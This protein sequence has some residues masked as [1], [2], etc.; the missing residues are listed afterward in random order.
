VFVLFL[1]PLLVKGQ[2]EFS[3]QDKKFESTLPVDTGLMVYI[4]SEIKG[5]GFTEEEKQFFYWSN[6]LRLHP[7]EFYK[8]VVEVFI[9]EFPEVKGREA[10][11]L[12]KELLSMEILSRYQYSSLLSVLAVEQASDLAL[13]ANQISHVDSNG[14]GFAERMKLGGVTKCAAENIYTGKNDGL[15]ALLMLL[16][17]LGLDQ[18]GHRKN[19]LNPTLTQ[20][21]LSIRPHKT[22]KRIVLVQIFGCS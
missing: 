22:E 13:K 2:A 8:G 1:F 19:I 5:K 21:G 7:K 17:D 14:R 6:Y 18:A 16:F 10:E 4:N 20:M 12:K 9:K 11:S 15:L 3:L